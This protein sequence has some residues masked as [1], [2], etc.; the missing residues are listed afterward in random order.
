MAVYVHDCVYGTGVDSATVLGGSGRGLV[1]FRGHLVRDELSKA[2]TSFSCYDLF[3][4]PWR[5]DVCIALLWESF[6]YK[7]RVLVVRCQKTL[8]RSRCG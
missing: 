5:S 7:R 1:G 2:S 3:C 8:T 6:F 4:M